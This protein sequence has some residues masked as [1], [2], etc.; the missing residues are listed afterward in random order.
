M[1]YI[2]AFWLIIL[3]TN[4]GHSQNLRNT[5]WGMSE[6][7]VKNIE[8]LELFKRLEANQNNIVLVYKDYM[9]G[10]TLQV[11]YQFLCDS[12]SSITYYMKLSSTFEKPYDEMIKYLELLKK[13]YNEPI[14]VNW[15]SKD[16]ESKSFLD[17]SYNKNEGM[18][19][20][21]V[22]G[23]VNS[24]LYSWLTETTRIYLL[25]KGETMHVEG[26]EF[27][28]PKF[29][30]IYRSYNFEKLQDKSQELL[31]NNKF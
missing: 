20:L 24:I 6:N 2:I 27:R 21:F 12:L 16:S 30:I 22:T 28:Y 23:D 3:L 9:F 10:D 5:S 19:L 26:R 15:D 7:E 25:I 4:E 29:S 31:V 1:K 18:S 8:S 11:W 13:K 14:E 17:N